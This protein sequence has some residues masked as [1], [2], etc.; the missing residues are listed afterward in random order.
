MGL[1]KF[2]GASREQFCIPRTTHT[3][4]SP[5]QT[6]SEMYLIVKVQEYCNIILVV[7]LH[8]VYYKIANI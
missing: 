8:T 2:V 7:R 4:T 5:V 1:F 6:Y 3:Q